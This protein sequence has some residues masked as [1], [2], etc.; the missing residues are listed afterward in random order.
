MSALFCAL[1]LAS[2]PQAVPAFAQTAAADRAPVVILV[3]IDGFPARALKDPR[4]PM[5]ALRALAASGAVAEGMMPI[6]PTVTWPNHTALI[7]G[8]N[9]SGHHVLANGHIVVPEDGGDPEVKPWVDK[10]QLVD[11]RTLYEAA[12]EKGLTTAQVDWVAIYGA[13]GVTWKFDEAPKLDDTISKELMAQGLVTADQLEHFGDDSSAAWRDEIWTDAAVDII[14]KHRSNLLLFH[15]LQTDTLQHEYGAMS[16][17]GYEAYAN[18]DHCLAR[19][20]EAVKKAGIADR[21]TFVIASDHGFASYTKTIHVANVL[22][23]AGVAQ[24]SG[25]Q[26]TGVAQLMPEGGAAFIY[27]RDK[28]KRAQ[29]EAELKPKLAAL[30]GVAGVYT[31]EE[32]RAIGIPSDAVTDQAPQLYLVAKLGYAFGDGVA[33]TA[34]TANPERGAHGYLNSMP[35]MQ[36]LFVASG[37]AVKPGVKLPDF[38]NLRVEPTIAQILGVSMPKNEPPLTEILK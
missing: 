10:D 18:A 5:P 33:P 14:E 28:A 22:V 13:K 21:T 7:T 9:A 37:V 29:L 8:V 1:L 19:V 32:A 20:V 6:N 27:I 3:T 16:S 25:R 17:A 11:A 12:T 23:E 36:A 4:L 24:G 34:I 30:E 35:E 26:S 2:L 15:L 38:P 31:N